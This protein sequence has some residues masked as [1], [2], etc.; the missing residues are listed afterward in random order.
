MIRCVKYS[1][2]KVSPVSLSNVNLL[3]G[4]VWIDVVTKDKKE[5]QKIEK[6][7]KLYSRDLEDSVDMHEVPRLANRKD[8]SFIILRSLTGKNHSIP[9]GIFLSKKFL[10]TIHP[11]EIN[12]LSSLFKIVH[13]KEGKEFFNRG[14][15]FL[16]YKIISEIDRNLHAD[17]DKF[18]GKIDKMEERVLN[19]QV[20]DIQ[21]VFPLKKHLTYYKKALTSNK[22]IIEKLQN[23]TSKF[24]SDKN[25]LDLNGLHVEITQAE[26]T[27]DFQREKLSSIS[28]M[29]MT[30]ISNRLND[31]MRLFTVVASILII[32]ML[33]SGIWGM[34][35]E[36]IPFFGF[37]YG[38][39]IPIG[40][41]IFSMIF[42]FF[43]Y[44][45]K[46]WV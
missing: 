29:Y 38:F 23:K 27:V 46:R 2:G 31:I 20:D 41:M 6:K 7:F 16:T 18:D 11:K 12:P 19:S 4:S 14:M 35:F 43:I 9:L 5:L 30:S 32:P 24:I 13:T 8:Y 37:P 15:D 25:F 33:I 1:G 42:L 44:K 3:R 45:R 36:K 39:Y 28:E 22:G 17:L 40:L 10:I 26:S 21:E 34:N